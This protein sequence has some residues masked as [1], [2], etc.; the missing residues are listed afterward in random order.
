MVKKGII[1]PPFHV[2]EIGVGLFRSVFDHPMIGGKT[3][4]WFSHARFL[5]F[6]YFYP[7]KLIVWRSAKNIR[8]CA[9]CL[10]QHRNPL[11]KNMMGKTFCHRPAVAAAMARQAHADL[12]PSGI[13][14]VFHGAGGQYLS[15]STQGY[16][17]VLSTELI[18]FA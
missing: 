16:R 2:I 9:E 3:E 10:V 7:N 15:Q 4:G 17:V 6:F 13:C 12:H 18:R 5:A 8:L 14:L 1:F 11:S